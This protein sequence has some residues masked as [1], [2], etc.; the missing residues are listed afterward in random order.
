MINAPI[1]DV[2]SKADFYAWAN[3]VAVE[4]TIGRRTGGG[5]NH[6]HLPFQYVTVTLNISDYIPEETFR[7]RQA[8]SSGEELVT[9][10]RSL[11]PQPNRVVLMGYGR[12]G[13]LR[14]PRWTLQKSILHLTAPTPENETCFNFLCRWACDRLRCLPSSNNWRYLVG[15]KSES[16]EWVEYTCFSMVTRLCHYERK[17]GKP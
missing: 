7:N 12:E 2:L 4:L 1:S 13:I 6:I 3:G 16:G 10:M 15:N 5:E 14:F 17:C 11:I 9:D 8:H